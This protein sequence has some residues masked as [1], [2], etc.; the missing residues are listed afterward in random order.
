MMK[1]EIF[2]IALLIGIFAITLLN[3]H[4]IDTLKNELIELL[5]KSEECVQSGDWD[6]A[7][8]FAEK[9]M[10]HWNNANPY[11]HI[12]IRHQE[13]DGMTECFFNLLQE[14]YKEDSAGVQA[15][16]PKVAM[17]IENIAHME[18][19]TIGTVF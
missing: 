7:T 12:F 14:I 3:V 2:A 11:T 16:F 15:A 18:H 9:A 5:S 4:K 13:I 1:K 19:L 17:R 10:D 8:E 6:G